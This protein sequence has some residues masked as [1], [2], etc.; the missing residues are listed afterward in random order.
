MNSD[1]STGSWQALSAEMQIDDREVQRRKEFLEFGDED[2]QALTA[3]DEAASGHAGPVIESLYRHFL[4]FDETKAFFRDP[5]V[6]ERVKNLQK[7]YFLQLTKGNYDTAY[8]AN[9]LQI[10]AIHER[11]NLAPKWYLG[12]YNFYLRAVASQLQTHFAAN[13]ERTLPTFLSLMK[14]VFLDIG[15]AVDAYIHARE[16]TMRTQQEA[17]R[18]LS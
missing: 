10:G 6:L 11:V 18:E 5:R 7:E 2:E 9:R 17:I 4:S 16:R 14:L 1:R 8:V 13:P 3:V 12:A 15:V